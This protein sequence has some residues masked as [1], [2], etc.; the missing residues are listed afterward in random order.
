MTRVPAYN[1]HRSAGRDRAYVE[2]NG[3]RH[4]LGRWGT[5]DSRRHY[6]ELIAAQLGGDVLPDLQ[7][8]TVT[9]AANGG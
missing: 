5:T 3:R 1:R 4:Y 9:V 2:L 7:P 6:Y 8:P